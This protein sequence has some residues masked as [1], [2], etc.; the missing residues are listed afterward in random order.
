MY[1]RC[2]V[3][4]IRHKRKMEKWKTEG[5]ELLLKERERLFFIQMLLKRL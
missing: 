3:K 5:S 1:K 4:Q 2:P